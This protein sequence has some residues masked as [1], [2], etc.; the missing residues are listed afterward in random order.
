MNTS[1]EK[2]LAN[3]MAKMNTPVGRET[4]EAFNTAEQLAD[5]LSIH[6]NPLGQTKQSG[7]NYSVKEVSQNIGV[8]PVHNIIPT[9]IKGGLARVNVPNVTD[10]VTGLHYS[11]LLLKTTN[12]LNNDLWS[13]TAPASGS[14]KFSTAVENYYPDSNEVLTEPFGGQKRWR[15][16]AAGI[17]LKCFAPPGATSTGV[18][19]AYVILHDPDLSLTGS[20]HSLSQITNLSYAQWETPVT[21]GCTIRAPFSAE[22][23]EFAQTHSR[24]PVLLYIIEWTGTPLTTIVDVARYDQYEDLHDIVGGLHNMSTGDFFN[25]MQN[26][27]FGAQNYN[28]Y[29]MPRIPLIVS[30][31]SFWS[32]SADILKQVIRAVKKNP[33][34]TS[35]LLSAGTGLLEL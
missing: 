17:N 32:K 14:I 2:H 6:N 12:V 29:G 28:P 7:S 31:N 15:N 16:I 20:S 9:S 34:L 26:N 4:A 1:N 11:G 27:D 33:T 18:L 24:S 22:M 5:Y 21:A 23:L 30:G 19:H 10:T 13:L 35:A 3:N 8:P 25:I